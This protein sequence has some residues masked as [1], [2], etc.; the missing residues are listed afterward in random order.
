MK[1]GLSEE[2]KAA[3]KEM[4]LTEYEMRAYLH[5]LKAGLSTASRLSDEA[6]IPY[7]KIYEVLNSLERKGWIKSQKGRP[8]LYYPKS[9]KESLEEN[10]LRME[11]RMR[12]WSKLIMLE[13][14]PI[15]EKREIRE[16]PDI[17]IFRGEPDAIAKLKETLN[18]AKVEVLIAAPKIAL[19]IIGASLP[20]L[21]ALSGSDIKLLIM[22]SGD[23][24]E[25]PAE[26][27]GLGEVRFRGGMFGGGIIV[28][29]REALLILGESKPSLILWSNHLD[30]VRFAKS[31]FYYLWETARRG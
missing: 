15:Y 23:L 22:L 31:Y 11:D 8:R 28:D 16:K 14:Q 29:E 19:P 2:V 20:A 13:L 18:N 24:D 6:N 5:L 7:S 12:T 26:L 30:L 10:R 9:P 25:A 3:L 1:K 4:G 27:I 21:R 17:W